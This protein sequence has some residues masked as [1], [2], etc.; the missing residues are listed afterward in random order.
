VKSVIFSPEHHRHLNFLRAHL[1][2]LQAQARCI[3]ETYRNFGLLFHSFPSHVI[4]DEAIDQDIRTFARSSLT[5]RGG[6]PLPEMVHLIGTLSHA[7]DR[8]AARLQQMHVPEIEAQKAM[9]EL[10]L[11]EKLVTEG[12]AKLQLLRQ[13]IEVFGRMRTILL[14]LQKKEWEAHQIYARRMKIYHAWAHALPMVC[15]D[16]LRE[17]DRTGLC[18]AGRAAMGL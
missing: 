13:A 7:V 12:I 2:R 16:G 18:A 11:A 17:E 6:Y 9:A 15:W 1:A 4:W 10:L 8:A 3:A 14:M 5:V